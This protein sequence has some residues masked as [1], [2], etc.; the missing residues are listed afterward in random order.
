MFYRIL[1]FVLVLVSC[2]P[3][4]I[5]N[6][7]IFMSQAWIENTILD[8][9]LKECYLCS[10]K[11]TNKPVVSLFAG[12]GVAASVDGTTSTASFKTPFGL[13]VDTSGNIYVSD[14]INN[15]IRKIDPSGNVK[16][17]STNLPLQDPSGIKFDPLTGD[18]YVSCKDS[19]QIYK[20][21]S[22]EQFSLFAGS[23]SDLSGLQNGDRL[24][25]LFDSPFFMDID[26]ERNLYVGELSNHTIRKINLNSG[27]VS[28]LSG[29]I[30]GYLD[31]DLA[32]ARFK[33]PLG[34][35]YNRKM[36]SLLAADIQD[37]R[38]RKID[39][40][41]STVSTLLGNGIGADVDGNGTN[42]SFF[43]P[44]FISI[45]N[46]GYMFVSDANSN[47]IRIVDPLLNVSTIDHTFMEIGTVKVDCLNQRLLVADSS[48]NQIFQVKFE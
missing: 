18:K 32:S 11:I 45:D 34:I 10:L 9:I 2:S 31:G 16:T 19:N 4:S 14:Q 3:T 48:A 23:S 37:H 13:E 17:L 21:D 8:C 12:T 26:P 39:L 46:S 6:P 40:K 27:T 24:N 42:A 44:A 15:L 36:N 30:S 41:N 35:A 7:S 22:T 43:G 5:Y 33:S 28:T 20:I 29:G 1:I 47:R 38:I 25:S